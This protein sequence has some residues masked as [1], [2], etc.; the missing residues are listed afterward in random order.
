MDSQGTEVNQSVD[1]VPTSDSPKSV[2]IGFDLGG[3]KMLCVV[4]DENFTLLSK[5]RRRTK[6]FQGA[7]AGV[8]R[9]LETIDDALEDAGKSAADL[10]SIGVGVPAPV[11]LD[12]GVVIEAVN[13]GW[14]NVPLRDILQQRLGCPAEVMNDVDA[15]VYGEYRFGAGRG[16][17]SVVGIFPGT[18]IGG[19]FVVHA[20]RYGHARLGHGIV[21]W[22]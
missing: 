2:R 8:N 11:D 4:Y 19:G 20:G 5:K 1:E 10:A 18:G 22:L 9:I 6:G 7:E 15:G 21:S 12:A 17:R 16:A 13:L 14:E 3:T